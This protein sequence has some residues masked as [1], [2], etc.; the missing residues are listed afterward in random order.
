LSQPAASNGF[1]GTSKVPA[2]RQ[3]ERRAARESRQ[4]LRMTRRAS[5][6]R[7]N[8]VQERRPK[9]L[10]T[11]TYKILYQSPAGLEIRQYDPYR[12]CTFDMSAAAGRTSS[13]YNPTTDAA[14]M[15]PAKGNVRAFGALAGYLFG[16]NQEQ[17]AMKMTAPVFMN[18]DDNRQ[19][20][21]MSFVL[22]SNYWGNDNDDAAVAVT[23]TT[24]GGA[25]QPPQPLPESGVRIETVAS[26][27]TTRAV[28]PFGGYALNVAAQSDEL[29]RQLRRSSSRDEWEVAPGA[30]V[31]LAQYNDPFTPPWKR[32]NE[33]SIAVIRKGDKNSGSM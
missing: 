6:P 24:G 4:A 32:L 7:R 19:T 33:V 21:S 1:D 9:D 28:W 11:P 25:Q 16:K 20:K 31:Q 26:T 8:L 15:E 17:V 13:S 12:V 2:I 14:T 3:I 29:L 22:P 30:T 10:E 23:S 5:S 27:E 18:T